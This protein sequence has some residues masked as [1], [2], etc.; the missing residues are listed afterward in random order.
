MGGVRPQ[1]RELTLDEGFALIRL[2]QDAFPHVT[3]RSPSTEP[4][5]QHRKRL[6][7]TVT[8]MHQRY[9]DRIASITVE[10]VED[11]LA[12]P[13]SA[14]SHINLNTGKAT[15]GGSELNRS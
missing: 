1:E 14:R 7:R 15:G 9:L 6:T 3:T 4:N 12:A 2:I 13:K 8:R 5:L 11:I 10:A